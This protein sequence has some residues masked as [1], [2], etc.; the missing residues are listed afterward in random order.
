MPLDK[1][2]TNPLEDADF[3]EFVHK[4]LEKYYAPGLAI[5]LVHKDQV[6]TAGFGYAEL[7]KKT[8]VT[9]HTIFYGA[10][11]TKSFTAALFSKLVYSGENDDEKKPKGA[12]S[13]TKEL[14]W[15]TPLSDLIPDDFILQD[16]YATKHVNII[17]ALSHRTGLAPY[18]FIWTNGRPSLKEATRFMRH[19]PLH[20][21][22]RANWEYSNLMYVVA[23]HA[24]ETFA[25]K[26]TEEML[27]EWLWKP[28]GMTETAYGIEKAREL[29]ARPDNKRDLNIARGYLYEEATKRQHLVDWE[30]YPSADGAGGISS[31]ATDYAKWIKEFL[32]PTSVVGTKAV[33]FMTQSHMP[34]PPGSRFGIADQGT[35]G[36]G[37]RM[38]VQNGYKMVEHGGGDPGYMTL[39][40]WIPELEWGMVLFT[41]SYDMAQMPIATRLREEFLQVPKESRFDIEG[42]LAKMK[43]TSRGGEREQWDEFKGDTKVVIKPA[44]DL[45]AYQGNYTH[46]AF[47]TVTI[48]TE[49]PER[50]KER[51]AG[52]PD[53]YSSTRIYLTPHGESSSGF[54]GIMEHANGEFWMLRSMFCVSKWLTDGLLKSQFVLGIDG[55]VQELKLQTDPAM[56]QL[57]SFVRENE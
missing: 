1:Y 51:E 26:P 45:K 20:N 52:V 50:W 44:L 29:V 22:L 21:E 47:G 3:K 8:P 12:A 5:G 54:W 14:K 9:P 27:Q 33:E 17:D 57:F 6:F 40:Q 2:E 39:I 30:D 38:G 16:E 13:A 24:L 4:T 18:D 43:E 46:P 42:R 10:S 48:S 49:L 15:T 31:T 25:G 53:S 34:S 32:K 11:T 55:Q 19:V 37:L 36:L 28:L 23:T 7:E 35:Y 56:E 41:N